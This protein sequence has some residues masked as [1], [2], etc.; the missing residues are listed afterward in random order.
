MEDQDEF[1]LQ[2]AQAIRDQIDNEIVNHAL[3]ER[4]DAPG[5]TSHP[6]T[7]SPFVKSAF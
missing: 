3:M 2:D 7:H 4:L 1:F 6:T 5:A